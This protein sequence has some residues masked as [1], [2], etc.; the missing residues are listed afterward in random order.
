MRAL[1]ADPDVEAVVPDSPVR[2][3]AFQ[4]LAP[5]EPV[6]PTGVR[7][8]GAGG[9]DWVRGASDASVAVID[10]GIDLE[11]TDLN[12][13]DGTDCVTP[14]TSADDDAGHGTH[15]AG[16][17]GALNNGSGVTG[18]APGTRLQAVK[19]LNDEGEGLDSQVICGID[20]AIAN[21][22]ARGI[23]VLNLSLGHLNESNR[24]C[25]RASPDPGSTLVDPLHDAICRATTAGLLSVAAAGNGHPVTGIGWNLS[26]FEY[27][28]PA[29]YPEVLTVSAI[30][31]RDGLPGGQDP[32]PPCSGAGPDD[33]PATFSNFTN[34]QEE[35]VHMVAAPGV[36]IASTWPLDE[37][38][39]GGYRTHLR[40]EHGRPARGRACRALHRRVRHGR[41]VLRDEARPD[42]AAPARRRRGLPRRPPGLG[43]RGRPLGA[44]SRGPEPAAQG[45]RFYGFLIR[46]PG[47][48]TALA[49]VPPETS[50]D[51]TPTF[52]FSSPAAVGFECRVDDGGVGRVHIAAHDR[53]AA[54]R[55]PPV[56]G[57]GGGP[58]RHAGHDRGDGRVHGRPPRSAAAASAAADHLR[59]RT[60]SP[61]Q[62]R[63][64]RP[65]GSGSPRCRGTACA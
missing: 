27:D 62:S 48:D 28:V 51:P 53:R 9:S 56:L 23:A 61:R 4:P 6:P 7:R 1:R 13:Q 16:T 36:C 10:T 15:V 40:H 3:L 29:S 34:S 21:R 33:G 20:W 26:E 43:L 18:V 65:P 30:A 14:G 64:R 58:R 41:P 25:G 31:D 49:S 38:P 8:I 57:A 63:T 2:A 32:E 54:R 22:V 39:L 50:E 24:N 12:A 45:N 60:C 59:R 35:A 5:G 46:P 47:P 42:R 19:V 52:A 55:R 44:A 11:H 17:V 37:A